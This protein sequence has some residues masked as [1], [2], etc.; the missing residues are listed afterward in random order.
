MSR[1]LKG[2]LLVGSPHSHSATIEGGRVVA[3]ARVMEVTTYRI[4]SRHGRYS[5][6]T[7]VSKEGEYEEHTKH[8]LRKEVA[9]HIHLPSPS[10]QKHNNRQLPE[11]LVHKQPSRDAARRLQ[12]VAS[13]VSPFRSS[14]SSLAILTRVCAGQ[15]QRTLLR[16]SIV[17]NTRL[18]DQHQHTT[19]QQDPFYYHNRKLRGTGGAPQ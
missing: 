15:L 4:L 5:R 16:L 11:D 7:S 18:R 12:A 13:V 19:G 9:R 10:A 6:E 17:S 2:K 1:C 3:S 8:G 14:H